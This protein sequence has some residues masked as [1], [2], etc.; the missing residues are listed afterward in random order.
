[1]LMIKHTL[2]RAGLTVEYFF[3]IR[4][5]GKAKSAMTP[6]QICPSAATKK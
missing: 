2:L 4:I 1:M 3:E 6:L 5:E